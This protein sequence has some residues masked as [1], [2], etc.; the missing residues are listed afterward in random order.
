MTRTLEELLEGA[1]ATIERLTPAEALAAAR[2][3]ALIVDIRS[4]LDR[5]RTGVVPGSVHL[6][7]TVL[8][9]RVTRDS[10]WRNPHLGEPGRR[11]VVLCDH[12]CSSSLAAATLVELGHDAADV[13]GGFEGWLKAGLPVARP[14]YERGDGLLAGMG[15]P[16]PGG[17]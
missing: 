16:E 11:L 5:S 15:P 14:T 13:I 8:E 10:T 2:D 9:W 1:R 12:G 6:P 4:E 7:R 17:A 3:G